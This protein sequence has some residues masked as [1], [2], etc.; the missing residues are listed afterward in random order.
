MLLGFS[1]LQIGEDIGTQNMTFVP[2]KM[3]TDCR[4]KGEINLTL[5]AMKAIAAIPSPKPSHGRL[6]ARRGPRVA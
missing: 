6:L 1:V 2:C 5:K 3:T 4:F